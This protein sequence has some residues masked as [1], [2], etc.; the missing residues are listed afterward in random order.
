VD[1]ERGESDDEVDDSDSDSDSSSE[2]EIP[3]RSAILI[4]GVKRP[5]RFRQVTHTEKLKNS[6]EKGH[7]EKREI[8][9]AQEVE[10]KLVFDDLKVV[11]AI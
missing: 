6:R 10:I 5:A 3:W 2:D 7:S 1:Q 9:K 4:A 11:E 8:D